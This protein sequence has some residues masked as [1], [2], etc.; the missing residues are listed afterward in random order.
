MRTANLLSAARSNATADEVILLAQERGW[1]NALIAKHGSARVKARLLSEAQ[2]TA[3]VAPK[4]KAK[5]SKPT[6]E[7]AAQVQARE[8]SV[9]GTPTEYRATFTREGEETLRGTIT[10][11][12]ARAK[13]V[14]EGVTHDVALVVGGFIYPITM[15]PRA[16]ER[17]LDGGTRVWID[18]SAYVATA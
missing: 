16:F 6:R 11:W 17:L 9:Q 15:S 2:G 1:T 14:G 3:K 12:P 8:V 5:E 18:G 4:A 13:L 10:V 7:Q